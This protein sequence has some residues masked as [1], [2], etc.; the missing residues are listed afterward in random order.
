M[1]GI[2]VFLR[3]HQS[4]H[5]PGRLITLILVRVQ[6]I[7][8]VGTILKH[9]LRHYGVLNDDH[10]ASDGREEALVTP[11]AEE[12]FILSDIGLVVQSVR[13]RVDLVFQR[14]GR[15]YSPHFATSVSLDCVSRCGTSGNIV[16]A[17]CYLARANLSDSLGVF[18]LGQL[19]EDMFLVAVHISE[20]PHS[21]GSSEHL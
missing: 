9:R 12:D 7:D 11:S 13:R 1:S 17:L 19:F 14:F 5:L 3:W 4:L 15:V 16:D 20:L 6:L 21:S 2:I 8:E 10:G 18:I